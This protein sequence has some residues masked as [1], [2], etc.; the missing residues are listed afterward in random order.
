M[1]GS[2]IVSHLNFVVTQ[3]HIQNFRPKALNSHK[4]NDNVQFSANEY[5]TIS[6]IPPHSSIFVYL[7][8]LVRIFVC[9]QNNSE[10]SC[11]FI[12]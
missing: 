7:A 12:N 11:S 6:C 5:N 2:G 10:N 8:D 9:F 1:H 4:S 3:Q